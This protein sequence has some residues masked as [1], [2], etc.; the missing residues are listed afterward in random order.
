MHKLAETERKG[1]S[2]YPPDLTPREGLH[3]REGDMKTF[4]DVKKKIENLSLI[5]WPQGN[6]HKEALETERKS[7]IWAS[8]LAQWMKELAAKPDHLNSTPLVPTG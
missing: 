5:G 6:Q 2:T 8:N 3:R 7:E 1:T 4:S